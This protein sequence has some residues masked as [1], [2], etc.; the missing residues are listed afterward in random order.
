MNA[1]LAKRMR[2][3][4]RRLMA[5]APERRLVAEGAPTQKVRSNGV[6]L[7]GTPR[8]QTFTVTPTL[9]NDRKTVRG[10]Y[11]DMKKGWA[12]KGIQ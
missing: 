11:R 6:N 12:H 10:F 3:H 8:T 4:A 9:A 5:G 2:Q 1:K 7:D